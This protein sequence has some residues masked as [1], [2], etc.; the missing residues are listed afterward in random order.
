MQLLFGEFAGGQD[1]REL[2]AAFQALQGDGLWET[3]HHS[4][5]GERLKLAELEE[6]NPHAGLPQKD[7]DQLVRDPEVAARAVSNLMVRFFPEKSTLLL[8]S[9]NL[10]GFWS[11]RVDYFLRPIAGETHKNRTVIRDIYGGNGTGGITPLE[12]GILAV[13]S[14]EKGPYSDHLIP[15]TGWVAYTGDGL[16]GDQA[17]TNGNLSLQRYQKAERALRYWHQPHRGNWSFESWVVVV[18]CYRRW[19]KGEDKKPRREYVWV[20]APVPSPM[21]DTWPA[22]IIKYLERDDKTVHDESEEIFPVEVEDLVCG[23]DLTRQERYRRLAKAAREAQ[24]GRRKPSKTVMVERYMRSPAAR[25][26]VIIRSDGRCEN[27]ACPGHSLEKTDAGQPILEVDHV[28]G[29]ALTGQDVPESMIALCPNCHA[30]KTRGVNRKALQ[31]K[32]R[33]R[34][35]ELHRKMERQSTKT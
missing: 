32:L 34:A 22:D 31:G 30:L 23:K 15:E 27:L 19:G 11:E 5:R 10:A 6:V 1:E 4:A 28:N 13:Y 9:L 17:M 12:D 20:L 18:Q 2:V 25:E 3:P 7:Y 33:D 35:K 16:R 29:L 26:A 14:R 21:R 24:G 8:Q